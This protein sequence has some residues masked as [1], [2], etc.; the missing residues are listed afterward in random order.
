KDNYTAVH[1]FL[2]SGFKDLQK[3][4][5]PVFLT[6]LIFYVATLTGNLLIIHLVS[7]GRQF[8][9]PMYFFL[10]HLSVCDILLSTNVAPNALKVILLG[11]SPISFISCNVQLFFFASSVIIECCLLTVMSYD[12]YLAI[13]NPLLYTT[14]MNPKMCWCLAFWPWVTGF[15]LSMI[16]NILISHLEFCGPNIIDHFFCDLAPLL[17]LSCSD[18]TAV[19][20]H[21]SIVTIVICIIQITLII[22]TYISIVISILK[23]STASGRKKA[24]STCSSHLSVVFVYYGTLITLYLAPARGYSL[25]LNKV[26][27]LL[28]TIVTPLFNPIIYSLRNKEI[29][30][31]IFKWKPRSTF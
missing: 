9:S 30:K 7:T 13:C 21:V 26:L 5:F 15:L 10:G 6:V 19:E 4:Q 28:N 18:T 23:I 22:A 20:I 3:F 24:F 14:I 17:E 1:E 27:S 29:R 8:Q 25:Q 12:R 16:N 31:A 11:R 2:I